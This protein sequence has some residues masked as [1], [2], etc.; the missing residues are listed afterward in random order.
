MKKITLGLIGAG[1]IG[2]IHAENI[3]SFPD[4][5]IKSVSDLFITNTRNWAKKIG[6]ST[7]TDDHRQILTD[8]N[9][10]A[11]LICS[12]TDTH[13]QILIEA[14]EAG[15]HIFCE[16]PLSFS[17]ADSKKA[18]QKVNELGIKLQVGFNRRFDHNFQRARAMVEANEIGTPHLIKI[19]SR[20]P[21]PPSAEYI[22]HSGGMFMDMSIHDF[23]MARFLTGSEVVE[24]YVQ[25]ATLIDSVFDKYNDVDTAIISLKFANSALGIIDNSRKAVYGYDQRVEI[26]GSEGCIQI[27]NDYPNTAQLLTAKGIYQDKPKFFFLERYREAYIEELRRF[28]TAIREN[29]PVLVNGFDALQAEVIAHAAKQSL[30]EG[31]PVPIGDK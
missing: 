10:D 3:Q 16:K 25:G 11:V 22:A 20:D 21:E 12:P 27:E 6:I 28:I 13:P 24:V 19:T 2:R 30:M 23:D 9:I 8:P 31:K 4:L 29:Q 7:V 15:K 18:I 1:R 5:E 14:A 17:L 26:F